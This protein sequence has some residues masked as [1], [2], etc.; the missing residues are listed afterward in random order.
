MSKEDVIELE[1]TVTDARPNAVLRWS[2]QTV[3]KFSPI[4]PESSDR[5]I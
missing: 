1:G 4:F 2:L 5:T 3:T